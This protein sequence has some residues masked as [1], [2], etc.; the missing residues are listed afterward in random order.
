MKQKDIDQEVQKTMESINGLS[1]ADSGPYFYSRLMAKQ[2]SAQP[3]I[4]LMWK[5]AFALL[6]LINVVTYMSTDNDSESNDPV[7]VLS[8]G[9]FGS[10][11][12][13]YDLAYNE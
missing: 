10:D 12:E 3:E 7:E 9:Y 1:P 8:S 6:V 13:F 4:K 2:S 11:V 5:L